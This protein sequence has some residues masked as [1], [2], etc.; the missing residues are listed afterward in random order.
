MNTVAVIL[1][2]GNSTRFGVENKLLE[3][4][5]RKTVLEHAVSSFCCHPSVDEVLMVSNSSHFLSP[6]F[7]KIWS[8]EGGSTRYESL[9]KALSFLQHKGIPN[10]SKIL[11]HNGANPFVSQEEIDRV[12]SGIQQNK[13]VGVGHAIYGTVR[14]KVDTGW[15]VLPREEL[16]ELQTPQGALFSDLL[17][18]TE[19]DYEDEITD[20]LMLAERNNATIEIFP[21]SLHNKKITTPH[22]LLVLREVFSVSIDERVGIGIDSHR[23]DSLHQKPCM[24]CGVT[25]DYKYGFLANSDGDVALHAL[26]NALL[27]ALGKDSFSFLAD[28]MC[29]AGITDSA[30]YLHK[31]LN[32]VA[33]A[34]KIVS[35]VTC[36]FEG[37]Y[38]KIEKYFPQFRQSLS[39]LLSL[40]P[41]SIGLN[42][43]TGEELDGF[44]KG[45]GMK[46][47]VL[48]RLV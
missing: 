37:K 26:C 39:T 48:V 17:Q 5:G 34:G 21:A 22:D 32:Y 25:V 18:W 4:V 16:W 27:S 19:V 20:E 24:I 2:N 8:C 43:T 14:K 10:T 31:V 13:A 30:E 44:G 15:K 33:D 45:E 41:D 23:F 46:C 36:S 28:E 29:E 35:S 1:A 12:I 3:T 47:T 11:V 9:K 42:A 7:D 38:P 40:A 6:V